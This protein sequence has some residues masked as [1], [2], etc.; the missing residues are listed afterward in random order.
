MLL[1]HTYTPVGQRPHPGADTLLLTLHATTYSVRQDQ[2]RNHR[3]ERECARESPDNERRNHITRPDTYL[4]FFIIV[5]C[6]SFSLS[7]GTLFNFYFFYTDPGPNL[8]LHC[9][10]SSSAAIAAAACLLYLLLL[11][12]FLFILRGESANN[13]KP[14]LTIQLQHPPAPFLA[15]HR[16]TALHWTLSHTSPS[17][18]RT[19]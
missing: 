1:H 19:I 9:L 13:T 3:S 17:F 18:T 8:A 5:F 4:R 16:I 14:A 12:P 7:L 2:S 6:F 11:L 15:S 10:A